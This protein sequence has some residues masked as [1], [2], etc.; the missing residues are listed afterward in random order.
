M[1]PTI[2]LDGHALNDTFRISDIR[3]PYPDITTE[4]VEVPGRHGQAAIETHISERHVTF[5]VWSYARDSETRTAPMDALMEL[6]VSANEHTLTFSDEPGL[7]RMVRVDGSL[8]HD[9][10]ERRGR[11]EIPFVMP[12]P[13]RRYAQSKIVSFAG[14]QASFTLDHGH[15]ADPRI[16]IA[17]NNVKRRTSDDLWELTFDGTQSIGIKIPTPLAATMDVDLSSGVVTV[18]GTRSVIHIDSDWPLE[19]AAGTHSVQVTAGSSNTVLAI[20]ERCI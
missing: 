8:D 7:V 14:T 17:A 13:F 18:D 11:V 16:S 19:L 5:R 12:D 9:E 15:P 1:T 3:R 20:V 10:Y 2:T 4:M 6:L